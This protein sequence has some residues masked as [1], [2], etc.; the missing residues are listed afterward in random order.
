MKKEYDFSK[1]ERGRFYQSD[2]QFNSP[3]FLD[4]DVAAFLQD[5]AKK[6]G[7]EI[8]SIVNDWLRK[9][10]DLVESAK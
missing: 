9:S 6:K 10:I 3:I 5:L 1:G 7:T 2:A 4:P 8:E